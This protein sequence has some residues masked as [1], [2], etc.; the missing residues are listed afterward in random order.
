MKYVVEFGIRGGAH[1]ENQVMHTRKQAEHLARALVMVFK[2]DPFAPGAHPGEWLFTKHDKRMTWKSET[3]FVAVSKLDGKPRGPA[4][5][6]L[7]RKDTG[8]S[9][10]AEQVIPHFE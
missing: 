8:P 2:N 3:H 9:L 10:L 1:T 6:G 7:W 5:A 4:S